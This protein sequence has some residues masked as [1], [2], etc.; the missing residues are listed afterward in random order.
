VYKRGDGMNTVRAFVTFIIVLMIVLLAI[1]QMKIR[2][3]SEV[4]RLNEYVLYQN[5]EISCEDELYYV[6]DTEYRVVCQTQF[7][8]KSGFSEYT[9]TEALD[10]GIIE[11]SDIEDYITIQL[12][13]ND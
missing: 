6:E 7:L 3:F 9:V 11:F 13:E 10:E 5:T 4:Q 2:G 8:L 12:S 1:F